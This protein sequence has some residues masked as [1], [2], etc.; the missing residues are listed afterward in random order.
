MNRHALRANLFNMKTR[1]ALSMLL[2]A[3]FALAGGAN[4]CKRNTAGSA[5]VEN[6]SEKRPAEPEESVKTGAGT[7]S[8]NTQHGFERE[9]DPAAAPPSAS[10]SGK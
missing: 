10:G 9:G 2:L 5:G 3:G 8:G 1:L 4:G 6:I 7:H